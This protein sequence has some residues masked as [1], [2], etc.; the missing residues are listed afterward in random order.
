MNSTPTHAHALTL[1]LDPSAT[2]LTREQ[3]A[4]IL[5]SHADM[6]WNIANK[7]AAMSCNRSVPI[8]DIHAHVRLGFVRA[9]S[10]FDPSMGRAFS[11][12]A[13]RSGWNEGVTYCRYENARGFHVPTCHPSWTAPRSVWIDRDFD[14]PDKS[15]QEEISDPGD[16]WVRALRRLPLTQK[17]VLR[18]TYR[19][20]KFDR[21]IAVEIGLSITRVGQ[22]RK[23]AL[24][25]LKARTSLLLMAT[26]RAA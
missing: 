1:A 3:M 21:E 11:T 4:A 9:A 23:E 14:V 26:G 12:Y 13:Y 18:G 25:K 22:I 24:R 10:K 5:A 20:G 8:E 17:K 2:S 19:D 16:F 6:I 15:S 7:L